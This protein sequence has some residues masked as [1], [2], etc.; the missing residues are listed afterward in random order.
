[1]V[2]RVSLAAA[3]TAV[4]IALQPLL[5]VGG[6]ASAQERD[7]VIPARP[8][9]PE[10]GRPGQ[11]PVEFAPGEILVKFKP[12]TAG[13]AVAEAHRQGG[14]REKATLRRVD[15]KVLEVPPGRE[16]EHVGRYRQNPNV[17]YAELNAAYFALDMPNDPRYMQGEQWGFNNT[18]QSGGLRDADIDAGSA[19]LNAVEAWDLTAGKTGVVVAVL[20]TGIDQDHEDLKV[21]RNANFTNSQTP[22]D[23]YGHGTHVAGTIAATTGNGKGVAGTCPQC[24]LHN[25]KVLGDNGSGYTSWIVN[26]IVDATEQGA[27][28]IN[29]SFGSYTQSSAQNDALRVAS[30]SGVVL[31]AAAGNDGKDWGLYPAAFDAPATA[32]Q[33]A[34]NVVA[35]AATDRSDKR[36]G[37][38]NWGKWVDVSAPGQDILSTAPNH[39][40]RLWKTARTYG[41]L[42]GTSMATPHVAG[43]AGLVITNGNCAD[44]ANACV[45]DRLLASTKQVDPALTAPDKTP[46]YAGSRQGR[47]NACVA[48]GGTCSR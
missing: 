45:N 13:Q 31:V 37:F 24:V 38:S 2:Q 39:S 6:V 42:N 7:E 40:N 29:M 4:V 9:R 10:L 20:D 12:G 15:V 21:G 33:K 23:R 25:V 48:V 28:V 16:K 5:G 26:G 35:V 3:V 34:V 30:D 44:R 47:I 32:T 11:D 14:G 22:D 43:I 18:G 46:L 41:W 8:N 19:E 1:M 17:L 36:A 27:S